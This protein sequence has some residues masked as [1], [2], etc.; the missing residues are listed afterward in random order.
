MLGA[1]E[2]EMADLLYA[3]IRRPDA[4]DLWPGRGEA[5]AE[6]L[7]RGARRPGVVGEAERA[8]RA[9]V[10][11]EILPGFER[12]VAEQIALLHHPAHPLQESVLRKVLTEAGP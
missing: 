12:G 4:D 8:Q 6:Q 2:A 11:V 10:V 9:L 7:D 5:G 3:C 1:E